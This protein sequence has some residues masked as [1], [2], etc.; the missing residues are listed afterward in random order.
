MSDLA[1][2]CWPL[3]K[4]LALRGTRMAV[5]ECVA[6]TLK[7]T[8]SVSPS[9]KYQRHLSFS[10]GANN[11]CLHN[12]NFHMEIRPQDFTQFRVAYLCDCMFNY[13]LSYI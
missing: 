1:P 11:M 3:A 2:C 12:F 5:K 9:P 10:N 13:N 8:S 4:C 6:H 7:D